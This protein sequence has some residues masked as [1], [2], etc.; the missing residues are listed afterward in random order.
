MTA[1][2]GEVAVPAGISLSTKKFRRRI[3]HCIGG[4]PMTL[5]NALDGRSAAGQR[6]RHRRPC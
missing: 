5:L 3:A 1:A 6:V 4:L 2:L